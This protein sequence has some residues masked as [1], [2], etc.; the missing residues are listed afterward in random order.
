VTLRKA[1]FLDRDG[2]INVDRGYVSLWDDFDFLP[3]VIDALSALQAA[4]Y[5]LIVV[6]NQSGIAR[7]YYTEAAFLALTDRIRRELDALGIQLTGTYYC[8]HLE[9]GSIDRYAISCNCRKP[10]PGMIVQAASDWHI[11]LSRSF[12]VGDKASDVDAGRAAGIPVRYFVSHQGSDVPES[13]T[14]VCRDLAD[15]V[16]SLTV[17]VGTVVAS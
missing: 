13:A 14:Q 17:P 12:I 16:R 5:L 7:G 15:C 4:G 8:P 1:A 2:V 11:D 6:T 10:A 9:K 3:G